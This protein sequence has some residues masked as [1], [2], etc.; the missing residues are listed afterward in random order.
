M[1]KTYVQSGP[2]AR[3][4]E[5]VGERWTILILQELLRGRTRFAQLKESVGGIAP[6]V[7]SDRLKT[8]EDYDVVERR[9]YSDHP[10]R[11]EYRL[12][13]K[14]HEL[15]IVAGALAVWGAKY[16]SDDIVLAHT[17]CGSAMNVIYYCPTCETSVKGAG[18]RLEAH[19]E[20]WVAD[21]TE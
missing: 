10:P 6:N 7:L 2:V 11:A 20:S 19:D 5:L 8:L 14:G 15:G 4:L 21:T 9:F 17:E 18:V 12:T 1:A 3:A 13:K 16:L